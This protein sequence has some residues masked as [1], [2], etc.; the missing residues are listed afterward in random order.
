MS[1]WKQW[2]QWKQ[3]SQWKQWEQWKQWKQWKQSQAGQVGHVRCHPY[4]LPQLELH[5][6][7]I[8]TKQLLQRDGI[9]IIKASEHHPTGPGGDL[10]ADSDAGP[11]DVVLVVGVGQRGVGLHGTG[12]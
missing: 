1:Q 3:W 10:L 2:K 11:G 8:R 4:L 12:D 9:A 6:P 7:V 5:L